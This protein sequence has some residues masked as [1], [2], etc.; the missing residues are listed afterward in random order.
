MVYGMNFTQYVCTG[1]CE[2]WILSLLSFIMNSC[3]S[4]PALVT[5]LLENISHLCLLTLFT[6]SNL[7][8][9]WTIKMK[10]TPLR[11]HLKSIQIHFKTT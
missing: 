9:Q 10:F 1:Y 7:P 2:S 4:H 8:T 11:S 6:D 3:I 5:A